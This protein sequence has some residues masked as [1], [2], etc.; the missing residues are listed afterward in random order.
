[1]VKASK[2]LGKVTATD[3]R[4][5]KRAWEYARGTS[6]RKQVVTTVNLQGVDDLVDGN[7]VCY[8]GHEKCSFDG[9]SVTGTLI[10]E[11]VC[12]EWFVLHV[13]LKKKTTVSLSRGEVQLVAL[14]EGMPFT[15]G[16]RRKMAAVV[17][18][19]SETILGLGV[20]PGYRSQEGG[21][22]E[23]SPHKNQM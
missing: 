10:P 5:L 22:S 23:N 9:R 7:V 17:S 20:Y 11:K 6:R 12:G 1:M 14:V 2:C 8:G 16:F 4:S 19:P 3:A 18:N 15:S 13:G 21:V